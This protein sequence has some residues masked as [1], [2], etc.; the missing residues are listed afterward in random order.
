MLEVGKEQV[1]CSKEFHYSE[2][3]L[4]HLMFTKVV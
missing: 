2:I 1:K 3:K 4:T